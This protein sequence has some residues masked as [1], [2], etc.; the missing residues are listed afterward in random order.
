MA[1]LSEGL[2]LSYVCRIDIL[3]TV[4]KCDGENRQRE[5]TGKGKLTDP[6]FSTQRSPSIATSRLHLSTLMY[7]DWSWIGGGDGMGIGGCIIAMEFMGGPII[8]GGKYGPVII[9]WLKNMLFVN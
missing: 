4:Q 2:M 7:F 8:G 9:G 5:T 3:Y 1:K 6:I